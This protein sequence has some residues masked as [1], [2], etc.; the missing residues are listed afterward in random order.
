MTATT[1]D[2]H[3][4][5]VI[6]LHASASSS[7][8]WSGLIAELEPKVRCIAPDLVGYEGGNAVRRDRR[9]HFD[10]E[11]DN[12][13]R[14]VREQT[15]K[16][17]G[18]LHLVGHSYGGA[19]AL[20]LALAYPSR[21]ASVTVYEPAQFLML[22][23]DGLRS[24]QAREILSLWRYAKA[25]TGSPIGRFQAA[26]RFIEYWSGAGAWQH[27]TLTRRCRF[28]RLMP[29]VV[30]EFEAILASGV[31]AETYRKLGIPVRIICGTRTRATAELVARRLARALPNVEFVEAEG[32]DHMGPTNRPDAINPLIAEHVLG[33]LRRRVAAA[34]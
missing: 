23:E 3:Q 20:Q 7:R 13:L 21:V 2:N 29:K 8:Q 31:S 4:P 6:C 16:T 24:P 25:R 22:F 15:G 26:R 1:I 17:N 10:Q 28:A 19:V 11:I 34:A 5:L 32:A 27:V 12:I 30:A 33:S 14:Q 18:P 9:F